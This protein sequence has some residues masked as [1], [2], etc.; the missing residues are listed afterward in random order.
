MLL[1]FTDNLSQSL[2]IEKKS[3]A[4]KTNM[5]QYNKVVSSFWNTIR[6]TDV[7]RSKIEISF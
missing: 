4:H 7:D 5:N 6:K 3:G 2:N 1:S